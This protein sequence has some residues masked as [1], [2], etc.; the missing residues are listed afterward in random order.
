LD[1]FQYIKELIVQSSC[2]SPGK[3][4]KAN[5][6]DVDL[7]YVKSALKYVIPGLFDPYAFLSMDEKH[8]VKSSEPYMFDHLKDLLLKL[9]REKG[10][11]PINPDDIDVKY[12]EA[13]CLYCFPVLFD[14]YALLDQDDSIKDTSGR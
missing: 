1:L 4:H 2:N 8:R 13:T 11:T 3:T 6:N 14:K 9:S 12:V 10:N 7:D 5:I